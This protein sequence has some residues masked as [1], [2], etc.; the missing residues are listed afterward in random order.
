MPLVKFHTT[1]FEGA[2]SL[3]FVVFGE[4]VGEKKN[5]NLGACIWGCQT[6]YPSSCG[7]RR[8]NI[9]TLDNLTTDTP[10]STVA[11]PWAVPDDLPRT[12]NK[13]MSYT[14]HE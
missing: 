6:R 5:N 14:I 2:F 10:P 9:L 3:N 11:M 1:F 13:G 12:R 8:L 7:P 4:K